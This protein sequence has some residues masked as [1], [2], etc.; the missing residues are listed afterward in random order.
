[1]LN[2]T[3]IKFSDKKLLVRKLSSTFIK[4]KIKLILDDSQKVNDIFK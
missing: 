2:V 1:M 3:S 4:F